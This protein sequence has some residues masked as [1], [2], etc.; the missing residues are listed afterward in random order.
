MR[1]E[2]GKK[3]DNKKAPIDLIP[4][5][6]IEEMAYTLAAGEQK[7]GTASWA[8]GINMR[9]L[10]SAALRHIGQFNSGQDLDAETQTLHISNAAVNL[11]FAIWM[12]KNRPDLDNRWSKRI[13]GYKY[14]TKN[15]LRNTKSLRKKQR[16]SR[17][18]NKNIRRRTKR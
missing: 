16:V 17:R 3:F 7:Y 18:G 10:I 6:A 13:K 2:K 15:N 9:R 11:A 12:Y 8:N 4:Y 1:K 14:E 5:E